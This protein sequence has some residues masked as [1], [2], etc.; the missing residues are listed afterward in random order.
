MHGLEPWNPEGAD[1]QSAAVAA[2]PHPQLHLVFQAFTERYMSVK[3]E[4]YELV[5]F[6]VCLAFSLAFFAKEARAREILE[7]ETT[8]VNLNPVAG[9]ILSTFVDS[10]VK[11]NGSVPNVGVMA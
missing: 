1:L 6:S 8:S 3:S 5:S 11:S 9:R 10:Q 4:L 2:V 7:F